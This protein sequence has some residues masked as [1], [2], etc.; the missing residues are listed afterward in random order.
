MRELVGTVSTAVGSGVAGLSG[1]SARP[2]PRVLDQEVTT[3][4]GLLGIGV[5]ITMGLISVLNVY[6]SSMD[7]AVHS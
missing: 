3:P 1:V 2:Q 7:S 6:S 5:C 4:C